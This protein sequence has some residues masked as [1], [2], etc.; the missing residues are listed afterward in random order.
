[1]EVASPNGPLQVSGVSE[2]ELDFILTAPEDWDGA[3]IPVGADLHLDGLVSAGFETGSLSGRSASA[4]L[5]ATVSI[6]GRD[7]NGISVSDSQTEKIVASVLGHRVTEDKTARE[8]FTVSPSVALAAIDPTQ[9]LSLRFILEA[10]AATGVFGGDTAFPL[11]SAGRTLS[12]NPDGPALILPDG[13]TAQAGDFVVDNRWIDPR[14]TTPSS[15]VPLSATP[16]LLLAGVAG[17]ARPR[18]RRG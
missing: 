11:V 3:P 12:L 14:L 9:P 8:E 15:A 18:R 4:A 1:M 5:T 2:M 13:W 6:F 10:V 17:L 7:E 16:P